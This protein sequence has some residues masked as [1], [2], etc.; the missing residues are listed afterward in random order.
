MNELGQGIDYNCISVQPESFHTISI[1]IVFFTKNT[2]FG[3]AGGL[4]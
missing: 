3:A 2:P 1:E 4:L